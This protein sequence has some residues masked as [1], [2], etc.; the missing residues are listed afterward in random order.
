MTLQ[1]RN[2]MSKKE[3]ITLRPNATIEKLERLLVEN[4]ISGVPVVNDTGELIGVVSQSDIL[5]FINRE[6]DLNLN[7]YSY[8]DRPH[9]LAGHALDEVLRSRQVWEIMQTRLY[10][11]SPTT[12]IPTTAKILRNHNIHRLLVVDEKKLVGIITAFDLIRIFEFPQQV[13]EFWGNFDKREL[14]AAKAEKW[15]PFN[16]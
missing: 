5:S 8:L 14:Q 16:S 13:K 10:T 9:K 7:Y 15:T 4:G 1:V 3:L 6:L 12:D 11:V 2:L